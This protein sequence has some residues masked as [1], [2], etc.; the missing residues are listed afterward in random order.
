MNTHWNDLLSPQTKTLASYLLTWY[1]YSS[2]CGA[3]RYVHSHLTQIHMESN[4]EWHIPSKATLERHP[5]ENRPHNGDQYIDAGKA[6]PPSPMLYCDLFFFG[7]CSN[8]MNVNFQPLNPIYSETAAD[9]Q[10]TPHFTHSSETVRI[11]GNID[12]ITLWYQETA[13]IKMT[14]TARNWL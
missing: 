13:L 2:F 9:G 14:A 6:K 3:N 8:Q 11:L 5:P 10:T 12:H 7:G 1:K 4:T